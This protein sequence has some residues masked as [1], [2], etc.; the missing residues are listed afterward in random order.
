MGQVLDLRPIWA[1][2]VARLRT[3]CTLL[4][5]LS[6]AP[7]RRTRIPRIE[8]SHRVERCIGGCSGSGGGGVATG[9]A[10]RFDDAPSVR[11]IP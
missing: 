4:H 7:N 5:V 10:A 1:E 11:P 8:C 9:G 2:G 6:A 3:P